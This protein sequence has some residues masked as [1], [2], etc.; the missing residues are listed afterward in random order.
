MVLAWPLASLAETLRCVRFVLPNAFPGTSRLQVFW[1]TWWLALK[2]NVPP[3]EALAYRL[4]DEAAAAPDEWWYTWEAM[5]W[6]RS[7]AEPV[8]RDLAGDKN[9]F[10]SWCSLNGLRHVPTVG[11]AKQGAWLH[12]FRAE[13][14]PDCSL[15]VKPSQASGARGIDLWQ[16]EGEVFRCGTRGLSAAD[17]TRHI[18]GR[19]A[20]EG[21]MLVQEMVVPHAALRPIAGSGVPSV[22]V[23]TGRWPNGV[24]ELGPAML[25]APLPGRLVSQSGPFRL[26]DS[27]TGKVGLKPSQQTAPVFDS[28]DCEGF[29]GIVLP[30]WAEAKELVARAHGLFPGEVPLIGW[31]V[32]FDHEGPRLCEA[33]IEISYYF[34]Q[35][36]G[37]NPMAK[38][39][40]GSLVDAWL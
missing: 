38:S 3:V 4:H 33:N 16:K 37:S 6:A 27:A 22:R 24:V 19:S 32:L 36:S 39:S 11:F 14:L 17:F 10:A 34:F 29:E 2:H 7:K 26:I 30:G 21:P 9:A 5:S 28:P 23:V 15:V 13:L 25:Q 18:L 8:A 35:L 1:S 40:L 20:K 31:D 12:P